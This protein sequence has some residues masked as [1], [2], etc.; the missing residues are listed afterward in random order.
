MRL[1]RVRSVDLSDEE[2]RDVEFGTNLQ[3]GRRADADRFLVVLD[4]VETRVQG[5]SGIQV[6]LDSEDHHATS[7]GNGTRALDFGRHAFGL[8]RRFARQYNNGRE[9]SQGETVAFDKELTAIFAF[10]DDRARDLSNDEERGGTRFFAG[11]RKELDELAGAL[12]EVGSTRR[13]AF[14]TILGAPGA[15]KTSLIDRF[16]EQHESKTTAFYRLYRS[17]LSDADIPAWG[18]HID[19]WMSEHGVERMV[20]WMDDVH[21]VDESCVESLRELRANGI[22][23][24]PTMTVL[25]GRSHAADRLRALGVLSDSPDEIV[26]NLGGLSEEECVESTFRVFEDIYTRGGRLRSATMVAR[27][28]LGWP[29]LLKEAQKKLCG[30]LVRTVGDNDGMDRDRLRREIDEARFA[31]YKDRI[32]GTPLDLR[33]ALTAAVVGEVLR[34]GKSADES[35]VE[36]ICGTALS[37]YYMRHERFEG[38]RRAD[39]ARLL[40]ETCVLV[41]A[42]GGGYEVPIPSM[43][44]WFEPQALSRQELY[45][46]PS[47]FD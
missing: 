13:V 20:L 39:F 7:A 3:G 10:D 38:V 1:L 23:G 14:R 29:R 24:R 5:E 18:R 15:G 45:L 25:V 6:R 46:G 44:E 35:T 17:D 12:D 19:G 32:V 16:V 30:E 36:S 9:T 8:R 40:I 26:T 21:D 28:S 47:I 11:R 42:A 41:R 33:P 4:V 37:G 27:L 34:R 22:G 31:Y 43:A 2:S